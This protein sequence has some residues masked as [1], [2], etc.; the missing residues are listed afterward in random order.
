M[1]LTTASKSG[2]PGIAPD[3]LGYEPKLPLGLSRLG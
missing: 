2:I 3:R 1:S